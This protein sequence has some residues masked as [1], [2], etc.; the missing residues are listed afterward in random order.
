MAVLG[1]MCLAPAASPSPLDDSPPSVSYTID[2]ING[3]GGWYR[4]STSGNY[5]VVHWTVNDP[6]LTS[7]SG[8]EPAVRVDGPT[9]GTTRTC[10]ATGAGGTTAVTTKLIKIDADPPV[11]APS[12]DRNPNAN[13]WYKS[14]VTVTW[15][16]SDS[17][18]GIASCPTSAT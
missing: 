14:S 1:L 16:G 8:C 12:P 6:T 4:G 17:T 11:F 18:S 9:T 7:T 3:T 2:G 5:V 10:T 15:H 13:G